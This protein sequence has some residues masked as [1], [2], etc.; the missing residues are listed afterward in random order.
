MRLE[1]RVI[2][3]LVARERVRACVRARALRVLVRARMHVRARRAIRV[4]SVCACERV[5]VEPSAAAA[6]GACPSPRGARAPRP[7]RARRTAHAHAQWCRRRYAAASAGT[8]LAAKGGAWAR[9]REGRVCA[10][11]LEQHALGHEKQPRVGVARLKAD[12]VADVSGVCR[13]CLDRHAAR[14]RHRRQPTWLRARDAAEPR[15]QQHLRQLRRLAAAGVAHQHE[16]L[17]AAQRG[18][19]GVGVSGDRQPRP[20]AAYGAQLRQLLLLH[21]VLVHEHEHAEGL[22][23]RLAQ[24]RRRERCARVTPRRVRH[25]HVQTM[26]LVEARGQHG[27][28]SLLRAWLAGRDVAAAAAAATTTRAVCASSTSQRRRRPCGCG[29]AKVG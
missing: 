10:H 15:G 7:A 25:R 29:S 23:L 19:D 16:H 5:R 6:R 9:L 2:V 12:R 28:C 17:R 13:V 8:S 20:L 21:V 27:L 26:P 14:E 3:R 4:A 18:A 11:L 24:R 1:A 22:G